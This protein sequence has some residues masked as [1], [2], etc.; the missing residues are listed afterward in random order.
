VFVRHPTC[1][2]QL[3]GLHQ[4]HAWDEG[5]AA[6]AVAEA[7]G[8]GDLLPFL[9]RGQWAHLCFALEPALE[10]F[11][12][13][14]AVL[15]ARARNALTTK[16]TSSSGSGHH[17]PRRERVQASLD[18]LRGILADPSKPP[19]DLFEPS[20]A[21]LLARQARGKGVPALLTLLRVYSKDGHVQRYGLEA[22]TG[23]LSDGGGTSSAAA[24]V[25]DGGGVELVALALE[26]HGHE[27]ALVAAAAQA[28]ALLATRADASRRLL[29]C[30]T[31]AALVG[32]LRALS[33]AGAHH[34]EAQ[35][36][37]LRAVAVLARNGA[38][39]EALVAEGVGGVLPGL[40]A[41]H[42]AVLG[43]VDLQRAGLHC[44]LELCRGANE[45]AGE[46]LLG[47]GIMEALRK[48]QTHAAGS[49]EEWKDL[50]AMVFE[51]LD[52]EE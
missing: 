41:N 7:A 26:T 45:A 33:S 23:L 37:G 34:L 52:W 35:R 38:H 19:P 28:I 9:S 17:H 48:V 47:G 3:A 39:L 4:G 11:A 13:A 20:D 18:V 10:H 6:Q 44:V 15:H 36:W 16:A 30:G 2:L 22:L 14:S 21:E 51:E 32:P 46:A 50:S 27:A 43:D 8:R 31:S 5:G 25:V 12:S 40:L 49:D 29:R 24:G 42:G 1:V